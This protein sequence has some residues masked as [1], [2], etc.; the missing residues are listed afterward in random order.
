MTQADVYKFLGKQKD[1][2]NIKEINAKLKISQSALQSN[3]STL[4]KHGDIMRKI[5]RTEN[6]YHY[7]YR[8]K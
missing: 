1:W 7:I 8:I 6:H 5:V 4:T 3:L 2:K